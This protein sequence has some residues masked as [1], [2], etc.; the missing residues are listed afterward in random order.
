M[1]NS[2]SCVVD[3]ILLGPH[4]FYFWLPVTI[5]KITKKECPSLLYYNIMHRLLDEAMDSS[6]RLKLLPWKT[7]LWKQFHLNGCRVF[8]GN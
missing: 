8:T 2:S 4:K 6:Y 7:K 3:L 1:Q 5:A